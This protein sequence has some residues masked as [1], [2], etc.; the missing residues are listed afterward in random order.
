[1]HADEF[2]QLPLHATNIGTVL[3]FSCILSVVGHCTH[4]TGVVQS[5]IRTSIAAQ[6]DPAI[7]SMLTIHVRSLFPRELANMLT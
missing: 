3:Q 7:A 5:A 6:Y 2:Q 1:M 4:M